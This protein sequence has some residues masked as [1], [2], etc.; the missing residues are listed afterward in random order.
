MNRC[1]YSYLQALYPAF[2]EHEE[3]G[4]GVDSLFPLEDGLG[5]HESCLRVCAVQSEKG[6]HYSVVPQEGES[7]TAEQQGPSSITTVTMNT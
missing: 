4:V 1:L 5:L 6:L 7:A 2:E 3:G